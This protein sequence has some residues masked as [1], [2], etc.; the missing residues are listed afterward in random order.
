MPAGWSYAYSMHFLCITQSIS[1]PY[2]SLTML[3]YCFSTWDTAMQRIV[4]ASGL[5]RIS[6][7]VMWYAITQPARSRGSTSSRSHTADASDSITQLIHAVS[8]VGCSKLARDSCVE[9]EVGNRAG[10]LEFVF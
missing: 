8:M 9:M 3:P 7:T 1:V 6:A 2:V 4:A 5:L 10:C